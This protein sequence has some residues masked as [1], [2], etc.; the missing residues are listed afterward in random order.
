[1]DI[2]GAKKQNPAARAGFDSFAG[3]ARYTRWLPERPPARAQ[4][5]AV[6]MVLIIRAPITR[7]KAGDIMRAMAAAQDAMWSGW[8]DMGGSVQQLAAEGSPRSHRR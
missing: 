1:M 4:V 6:V 5:A 8:N 2:S 3:E 7:L